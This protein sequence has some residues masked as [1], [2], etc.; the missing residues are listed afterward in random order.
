MTCLASDFYHYSS[1]KIASSEGSRRNMLDVAG[2]MRDEL[3]ETG[4]YG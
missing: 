4:S 1:Q 3:V 2:K